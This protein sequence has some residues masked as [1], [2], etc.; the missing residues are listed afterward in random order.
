VN[1]P[2]PIDA[3]IEQVVKAG[4]G[5]PDALVEA[6]RVLADAMGFEL[7]AKVPP[8]LAAGDRVRLLNDHPG[9]KAGGLG[10]VVG[11]LG[12]TVDVHFDGQPYPMLFGRR[13]LELVGKPDETA[14][15]ESDAEQKPRHGDHGTCATCGG[16][17]RYHD[18]TD[19]FGYVF[20]ALWL[21]DE[22]IADGHDAALGG[23]A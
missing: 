14:G 5:D 20:H 2:T 23:P 12:A 6:V 18:S 9:V 1:Q 21:H 8:A 16:G 22:Q 17:I 3:A 4:S 7:V 13:H 11:L 19:H 15:Y 10:D